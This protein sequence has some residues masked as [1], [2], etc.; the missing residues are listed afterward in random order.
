[1]AKYPEDLAEIAEWKKNGYNFAPGQ[2]KPKEVN[3]NY[4]LEDD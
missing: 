3:K 1:M 2:Y 4:K